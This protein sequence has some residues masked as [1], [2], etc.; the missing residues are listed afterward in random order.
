LPG[1]KGTFIF[2]FLPWGGPGCE[3]LWEPDTRIFFI[4]ILFFYFVP[5]AWLGFGALWLPDTRILMTNMIVLLMPN[6]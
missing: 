2:Y 3:A 5:G 1:G 6:L 4:L